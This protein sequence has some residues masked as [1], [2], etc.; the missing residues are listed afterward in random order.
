MSNL[1]RTEGHYIDLAF[2]YVVTNPTNIDN[3]KKVINWANDRDYTHVRL[4]N[5]IYDPSP[6]RMEGVKGF[7]KA[8]EMDDSKI[9][10]QPRSEFTKGVEDCGISLLKPVIAADGYVYPCCGVQYALPKGDQQRCFPESMR[11][12]HYKDLEEII[13]KQIPFDGSVCEKCYYDNY[14]TVL[15][16]MKSEVD[17][18]E[19]V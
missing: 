8:G 9:I 12:G 5:D 17:H 7:L 13:E 14:N 2:S 1:R 15:R 10:Y 4:V 6:T 11:M 19:F 18:K 3:L 16:A